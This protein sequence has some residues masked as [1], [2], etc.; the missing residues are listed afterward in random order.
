MSSVSKSTDST[1]GLILSVPFVRRMSS[2][3]VIP[4]MMQQIRPLM[5]EGVFGMKET[6]I[7]QTTTLQRA[8]VGKKFVTL[9]V[10]SASTG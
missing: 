8:I 4:A 10:V 7:R 5:K 6:M 9:V 1:A 3:I 2:T